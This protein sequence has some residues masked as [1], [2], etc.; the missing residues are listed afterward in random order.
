MDYDREAR[1]LVSES[2]FSCYVS[3]LLDQKTD[4][5]FT[6]EE[7]DG[8]DMKKCHHKFGG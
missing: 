4:T 6:G 8:V 1:P 7:V 3:E 2:N 5:K